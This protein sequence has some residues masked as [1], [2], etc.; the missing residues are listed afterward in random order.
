MS[1]KIK[2]ATN[3][4]VKNGPT[5]AVG[6]TVNAEAYEKIQVL[7]AAAGEEVVNLLPADVPA[8]FLLITAD[9]FVGEDPDTQ[10]L[11]YDTGG[12]DQDLTGPLVLTNSA[13]M[14]LFGADLATVTFK[15]SMDSDVT[16]EVLVARDAGPPPP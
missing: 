6:S 3:V 8:K 14:E 4:A 7:V 9:R 15:N 12:G 5:F 2:W 16:I 11:V 1:E 13:A 10:K